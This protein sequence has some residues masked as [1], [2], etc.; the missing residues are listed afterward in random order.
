MTLRLVSPLPDEVERLMSGII[1]YAADAGRLTA[2]EASCRPS[3]PSC[4]RAIVPTPLS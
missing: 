4:L 2:W 3:C 1:R